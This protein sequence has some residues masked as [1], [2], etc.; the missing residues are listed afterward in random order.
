[1]HWG[2]CALAGALWLT[3]CGGEDLLTPAEGD[4]A[5]VAIVSGDAQAGRVGAVLASPLVVRVSD[6]RGRP[7]AGSEVTFAVSSGNGTVAPATVTTDADGVASAQWTL[8]PGVGVQTADARVTSANAPPGVRFFARASEGLAIAAGDAQSAPAGERLPEPLIV[9]VTDADN[10]PIQGLTITWAALGGGS[11]APAT[12][13]TGNDG[14]AASERT[15][16]PALGP[17]TTTASGPGLLG[18]VTFTHVATSGQATQILAV[19]GDGQSG[20]AGSQLPRPLVIGVLDADDNPVAG[21]SVSWTI[22]EGGGTMDPPTSTTGADGTASSSWTLGPRAGANRVRAVVSDLLSVG[23]SATASAPPAASLLKNGGD[24]QTGA[25][26][27]RLGAPLSVR[28]VDA[29]GN[30]VAGVRITWAVTA[31]GARC[32]P[33]RAPR[34]RMAPRT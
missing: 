32:L 14:R 25:G 20:A 15:L 28:A 9:R 18:S 12:S 26:L 29:N 21:A 13:T 33:R 24:G 1:M 19:S 3:S 34:G 8:G 16:G 7:V 2:R 27:A 31:A 4:A 10:R 17:Q 6:A 22:E 30:G 23:F 11:V 5:V